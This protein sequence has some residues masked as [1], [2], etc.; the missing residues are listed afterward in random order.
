MNLSIQRPR[1]RS[2]V[3]TTGILFAAAVLVAVLVPG[4]NVE[5]VT[6]NVHDNGY[7]AQERATASIAADSAPAVIGGDSLLG[8]SVFFEPKTHDCGPAIRRGDGGFMS[9]W[10]RPSTI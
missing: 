10:A 9:H 8:E 5:V 7:V 3:F 1:S 4:K 2:V 6:G